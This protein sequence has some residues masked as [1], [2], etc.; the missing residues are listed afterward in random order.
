METTTDEAGEEA[1]LVTIVYEGAEHTV[2]ANKVIK[3][4]T[5]LDTSLEEL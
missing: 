5:A 3:V 1:F 2:D 4:L